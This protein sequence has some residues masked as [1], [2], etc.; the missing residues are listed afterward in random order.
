MLEIHQWS[1]IKDRFGGGALI[2]GK[3][4]K[5]TDTSAGCADSNE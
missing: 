2:L 4:T 3:G 5:S 1:D